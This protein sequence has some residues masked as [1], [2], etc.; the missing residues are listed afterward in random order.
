MLRVDGAEWSMNAVGKLAGRSVGDMDVT[1]TNHKR[2][3]TARCALS[4]S[5]YNWRCDRFQ[6]V[7]DEFSARGNIS[8][9]PEKFR[10][11]FNSENLEPELSSLAWLE[12]R[13][14][15]RRGDIEFKISSMEG[16]ASIRPGNRRIEYVQTNT[17]LS[18]LPV[19][20]PMPVAMLNVRGNIAAL[21]SDDK[22]SF[23]FTAPEWSL[24]VDDTDRFVLNHNDARTLVGLI[25]PARN[26]PFVKP[27]LPIVV[28][29]NY[30]RNIISSIGIDFEGMKIAGELLNGALTLRT[31]TLNF[32][33][34]LDKD[35]F[36]NF[37]DNQYL[38]NDPTLVPFNFGR[39]IS[40]IA[41]NVILNG[42]RYNDFIYSVAG[43]SQRMSVSDSREG[44]LLVSITKSGMN[45]RYLI[46]LRRF[47]IPGKLMS[48]A[49]AINIEGATVTAEA[50]LE[51]F[52]LTA[53]DIRQNMNGIVDASIDGGMIHGL[54]TDEF[55]DN[56]ARVGRQDA[57]DA[58]RRALS[59]G[60]T[61]I[62][63][64][65]ITGE[66]TGGDFRTTR[67]FMLTARHVDMTGNFWIRNNQLSARA[68][69]FLRGTSPV[70]RPVRL[71]IN[72][73]NKSFSM[74]EIMRGIDLEYL[75]EFI[76]TH[77]RF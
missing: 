52:G 27:N 29:G 69:I 57:E 18:S 60:V 10:L 55:Y 33:A 14:G 48:A 56:A 46:Q 72:G 74:S 73:G 7:S 40:V 1:L 75:R 67:P 51:T 61:R 35:W 32:D 25:T 54:G 36:D 37:E 17:R 59:G 42:A 4:G 34:F 3:Q 28:T 8:V 77:N 19:N 64:L 43:D 11:T 31:D 68:N 26:L 71:D 24:S 47:F 13:A 20:V 23:S 65:E 76:R 66:Y 2:R 63:E 30:R 41:K 15:G 16:R 62:R 6:F 70:P 9:T 39:N 45:Y 12:D 22:V 58:V 44:S 49:S 53:Y 38:F 5:V 50:A 21:I